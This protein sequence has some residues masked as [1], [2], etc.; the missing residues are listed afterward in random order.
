[1]SNDPFPCGGLP[2]LTWGVCDAEKY[3]ISVAKHHRAAPVHDQVVSRST[4]STPPPPRFSP[5]NSLCS[6]FWNHSMY[7]ISQICHHVSIENMSERD[8]VM[9]TRDTIS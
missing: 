7:Q 4:E 1:M 2:R 5:I 9:E 3:S 6:S 8:E